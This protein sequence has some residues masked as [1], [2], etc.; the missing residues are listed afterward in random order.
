MFF[1][2]R[3]KPRRVVPDLGARKTLR[4]AS[5]CRPFASHIVR[6]PSNDRCSQTLAGLGHELAEDR[7]DSQMPMSMVINAW[8]ELEPHQLSR[9]GR[10][11]EGFG[12]YDSRGTRTQ[13]PS[14]SR[15]RTA[16]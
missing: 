7:L 15:T 2:L 12:L 9:A 4:I 3:L 8:R 1:A 13:R 16:R 11:Q 5:P 6:S 14:A 10:D